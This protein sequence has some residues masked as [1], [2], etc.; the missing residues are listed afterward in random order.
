M[1][2]GHILNLTQIN[3]IM[4]GKELNFKDNI[5]VLIMTVVFIVLLFTLKYI[6]INKEFVDE[7]IVLANNK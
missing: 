5:A 2:V 4:S 3:F 1:F 6:Q 7:L